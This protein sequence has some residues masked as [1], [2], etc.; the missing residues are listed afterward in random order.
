MDSSDI[1]SQRDRGSRMDC[2]RS[3]TARAGCPSSGARDSDGGAAAAAL[4]L[5]PRRCCR[6]HSP[7]GVRVQALVPMSVSGRS[8]GRKRRQKRSRR[9]RAVEETTWSIE[10]VAAATAMRPARRH[11]SQTLDA[12]TAWRRQTRATATAKTRDRTRRASRRSESTPAAHRFHSAI[13][14]ATRTSSAIAKWH[15]IRLLEWLLR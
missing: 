15:V 8:A 2:G 1:T 7:H 3:A 6:S 4:P 13:R 11:G 10:R 14:E 9:R 5:S 12:G